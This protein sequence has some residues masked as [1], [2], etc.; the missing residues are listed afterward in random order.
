MSDPREEISVAERRELLDAAFELAD[1]CAATTASIVA[2]GFD[3]ST[4]S[5]KSIVTT[6]DMETERAFRDRIAERFPHMD[7]LGEEFGR[8]AN[9]GDFCWVIDPIDG[10]AEFAR[11]VP[12]YGCII[13]LMYKDRPLLGIIDHRA[14]DLRCHGVHG[15][16]AFCNGQ[17]LEIDDCTA[18]EAGSTARIGLPS[19]AS[20]LKPTD[21]GYV[22]D[23]IVDAY[24]NFRA[25]HTCYA[26]LLAAARGL[27]AAMEWD[28]PLWDLAAAEVVIEEAGGRYHPVR[29]IELP[30]KGR[31]YTAV[32]GKPAVVERLVAVIE[33]SLGEPR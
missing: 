16:G 25:Y 7:V 9:G 31:F 14:M 1:L 30:G 29:D 2:T 28:T 19:R 8:S 13:G 27:D 23:A 33:G 22:F 17:K 6:A 26:H 3:V 4:K 20:F 12:L 10:T 15:L 24:P 32:F 21:C 5:D 11:H 18:E